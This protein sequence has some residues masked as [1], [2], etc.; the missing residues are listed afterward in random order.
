VHLEGLPLGTV[1]GLRVTHVFPVDAEN[2]GGS[3]R[4]ARVLHRGRKDGTFTRG[5]QLALRRMLASPSFVFRPEAEPASVAVGTPY[6]IS[7]FEL[8]SRLSFFFWS[9]IP[10]CVRAT[11]TTTPSRS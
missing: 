5:V 11:R 3:R 2:A 4:P 6:G 7:D 10:R 9:T 1:G 8:A